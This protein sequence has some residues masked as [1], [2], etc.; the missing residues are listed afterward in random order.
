MKISDMLLPIS[1]YSCG[2]GQH[3]VPVGIITIITIIAISTFLFA[4][5]LLLLIIIASSKPVIA[6]YLFPKLSY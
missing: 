6:N 5:I 4:I 3:T 1:I 2:S